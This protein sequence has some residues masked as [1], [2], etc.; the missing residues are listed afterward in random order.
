MT[1]LRR[2]SRGR[3]AVVR[4]PLFLWLCHGANLSNPA[5][6]YVFGHPLAAAREA[7]GAAAWGDTDAQLDA[8]RARVAPEA[9]RAATSAR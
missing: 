3:A 1:A 8:L 7:V 6:R 9:H 2:R 5:R 4:G